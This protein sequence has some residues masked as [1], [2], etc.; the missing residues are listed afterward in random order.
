MEESRPPTTEDSVTDPAARPVRR[1]YPAEYRARVLA[2]YEAAP[3]GQKSAVLRREG[4]YQTLVAEWAK[5]RDAEAAGTTYKRE[6]KSRSKD[7]GTAVQAVKLEAENQRLTQ[8]LAQT[9]AALDVMGKVHGLLE[10]LSERSPQSP[11]ETGPSR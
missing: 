7:P 11:P 1:T 5:A 6:R 10:L 9:Q 3:H 8:Q 2:E 4:I